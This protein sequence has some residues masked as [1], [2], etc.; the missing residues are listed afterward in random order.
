V[1]VHPYKKDLQELLKSLRQM[2]Q[3]SSLV[4]WTTGVSLLLFVATTFLPLWRVLP[5]AEQSPF[6][7]LHYNI[8]LGVDRFGP[9]WHIFF[10][11]AISL[12]FLCLNT[13]IQA[14]SYRSQKTLTFFFAVAN[15]LIQGILLVA[16]LLIILIL[17]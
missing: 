2:F 14:R 1:S 16:M 13:L 17:L 4:R 8:Y 11:P 3:K 6:I 12:F 5:L 9:V 7:A 10:I 15:P